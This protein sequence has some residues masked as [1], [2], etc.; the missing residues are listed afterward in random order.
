MPTL[1]ETIRGLVLPRS[2]FERLLTPANFLD[3]IA[4]LEAARRT[5]Q[6][7]LDKAAQSGGS[8]KKPKPAAPVAGSV[9]PDPQFQAELHFGETKG[10]APTEEAVFWTEPLVE[11]KGAP[12]MYYVRLRISQHMVNPLLQ[13]FR[14]HWFKPPGWKWT[15]GLGAFTV[16]EAVSNPLTVT[17][18]AQRTGGA[19]AKGFRAAIVERY[20]A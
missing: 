16:D 10:G 18:R 2:R 5:Q 7:Q 14:V 3:D 17:R 12:T 15:D 8:K 20:Q 9:P 13:G 4:A 1:D 6:R 19:S 11:P